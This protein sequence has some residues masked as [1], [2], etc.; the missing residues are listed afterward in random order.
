M[1]SLYEAG[2][3]NRSGVEGARGQATWL[4]V[5]TTACARAERAGLVGCATAEMGEA[6]IG[7]QPVP[8]ETTRRRLGRKQ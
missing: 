2:W 1:R 8:R 7:T 5:Q 3:T 4:E 6:E